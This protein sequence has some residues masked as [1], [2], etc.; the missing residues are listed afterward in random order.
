[1]LRL[2]RPV[3]NFLLWRL[4]FF[5]IF[6]MRQKHRRS[7]SPCNRAQ[8]PCLSCLDGDLFLDEILGAADEASTTAL[9]YGRHP[10]LV[11]LLLIYSHLL[12]LGVSLLE[13]HQPA[14]GLLHHLVS[15][16]GYACWLHRSSSVSHDCTIL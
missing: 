13:L 15:V 3:H 11:P 2:G 6:F 14:H 4:R 7:V 12:L 9:T 5:L 8:R 16:R 10:L 1:M